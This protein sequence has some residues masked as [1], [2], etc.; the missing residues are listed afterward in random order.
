MESILQA[1]SNVGFPIFM[2]IYLAMRV[3]TTI[4]ELTQAITKLIERLDRY[5]MD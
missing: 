2:A 3:E 1:I 5:E 4:K